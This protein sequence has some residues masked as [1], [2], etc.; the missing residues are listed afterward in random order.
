MHPLIWMLI[1]SGLLVILLGFVHL[2][3]LMHRIYA[4]LCPVGTAA[5]CL[6]SSS[7]M[8]GSSGG[9]AGG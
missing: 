4:A 2:A 7:L 5:S 3:R 6:R 8:R 1:A 9:I